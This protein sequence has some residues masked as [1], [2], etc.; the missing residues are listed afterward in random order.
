MHAYMYAKCGAATITR[1]GREERGSEPVAQAQWRS[2]FRCSDF[3]PRGVAPSSSLAVTSAPAWS[4]A[5]RAPTLPCDAAEC[6]G[7]AWAALRTDTSAL[8]SSRKRSSIILSCAATQWSAAFPIL[9]LGLLL[10]LADDC[11]H[12]LFRDVIIGQQVIVPDLLGRFP[13]AVQR[14]HVRLCLRVD[15]LLHDWL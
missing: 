14:H 12:S 2:C 7:V 10:A 15:F 4:R 9:S 5:M 6:S 3:S 1:K 11:Q 13:A 8:L